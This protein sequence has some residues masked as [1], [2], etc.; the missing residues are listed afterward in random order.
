MGVIQRCRYDTWFQAY[1]DTLYLWNRK[2]TEII[3]HLAGFKTSDEESYYQHYLELDILRDKKTFIDDMRTCYGISNKIL[4]MGVEQIKTNIG[5]ILKRVD[6]SKCWYI[7]KGKQYKMASFKDKFTFALTQMDQ[8]ARNA[9]AV[10]SMS[11]STPSKHLH[12]ET[13]LQPRSNLTPM[14]MEKLLTKTWLLIF[15]ALDN[16]QSFLKLKIRN[17]ALD[18]FKNVISSNPL[19]KKLW[20]ETHRIAIKEGDLVHI[21]DY[22]GRVM[23]VKT[24]DLG[25]RSFQIK[26]LF[27]NLNPAMKEDWFA[28]PSLNLLPSKAATVKYI[29]S[30][31]TSRKYALTDADIAKYLKEE[32]T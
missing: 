13:S 9:M 5:E 4:A 28:A 30:I 24:H 17:E 22:V 2:I 23:K 18:Q 6:L 3:V 19:M 8:S 16:M 7:Q 20:E 1:I 27:P 11:F 31:V 12:F 29:K 10:Y 25:Y 14:D 32:K 15:C 21:R 26:F